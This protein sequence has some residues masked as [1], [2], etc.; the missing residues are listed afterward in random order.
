[1]ERIR[2]KPERLHFPKSKL[3]EGEGRERKREGH[4][5]TGG[6]NPFMKAHVLIWCYNILIH[7]EELKKTHGKGQL[8]MFKKKKKNVRFE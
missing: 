1:M 2:G 7:S 5:S 3:T 6:L 8:K 4:C